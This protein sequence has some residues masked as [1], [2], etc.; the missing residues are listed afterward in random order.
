MYWLYYQGGDNDLITEKH[1][2]FGAQSLWSEIYGNV[3]RA[4]VTVANNLNTT[5]PTIDKWYH[6]AIAYDGAQATLYIDGQ[7]ADGPTAQTA[8]ADNNAPLYIMGWSTY[9]TIGKLD[10][11]R[12]YARELSQAEIQEIINEGETVCGD[13]VR[14]GTEECE[15]VDLGGN[16]CTTIPGGF[17]SGTLSCTNIC[18]FNT[19]ACV[20]PPPVTKGILTTNSSDKPFYITNGD[21]FT[22]NPQNCSLSAGENC[23]ITWTVNATGDIDTS[24]DVFAIIE[25]ATET[26]NSN[27]ITVNI[28]DSQINAAPILTAIG[29]KIVD[30]D[31]QLQFTLIYSD[32][33]D[34]VTCS[35]TNLPAL[36]TFDIPTCTFSWTPQTLDIGV[37][38][39]IIFTVT[40]D[41]MP[42]LSDSETIN[43]FCIY[44][45]S[46]IRC[47]RHKC[48]R[49]SWSCLCSKSC[50]CVSYNCS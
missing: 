46:I 12:V 25:S 5:L 38:E 37:H 19:S 4:G 8:P 33:G 22:I 6:I 29:N 17:V 36:A 28:T 31:S 30:E 26:L 32:P 47:W 34:T 49:D 45:C 42:S 10:D 48:D 3:L 50:Y 15:V 13:G 20:L 21:P 7:I 14:N 16:T 24:W 11:L 39:N 44:I 41:G 2:A 40:D 18:T 27:N 1:G 23:T 9:S 35:A 43:I